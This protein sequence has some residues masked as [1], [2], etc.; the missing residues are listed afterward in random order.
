MQKPVNIQAL[1]NMIL[2][3]KNIEYEIAFAKNK[4]AF[5]AQKWQ[6]MKI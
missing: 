6:T 3:Y 4:I 2:E 5:H 1:R